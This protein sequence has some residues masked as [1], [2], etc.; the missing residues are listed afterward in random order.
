[1]P[2]M[3]S[4]NTERLLG[5]TPE[6]ISITGVDSVDQQ[7]LI[8]LMRKGVINYISYLPSNVENALS[9]LYGYSSNITYD[10]SYGYYKKKRYRHPESIVPGIYLNNISS[11]SEKIVSMSSV[12]AL[13]YQK[14]QLSTF[15][16]TEIT[17][18]K[19]LINEVQLDK[20]YRLVQEISKEYV[21]PIDNSHI[22]NALLDHLSKKYSP[23]CINF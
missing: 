19:Q 23:L 21:I 1:L 17:A 16:L 11:N 4:N 15:S 10:R 5:E 7:I 13:L 14:L 12:S 22:L 2:I 18:I 8:S 3:R 20:L 9:L 6:D